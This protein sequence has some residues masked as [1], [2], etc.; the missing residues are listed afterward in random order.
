MKEVSDLQITR[1]GLLKGIFGFVGAFGLG[2][3]LY[4]AYRFMAPGA[5]AY[6]PVEVSLNDIPP[7]GTYPFQYG[8]APGLLFRAEDGSLRAFSLV[9][10][11]LACTVTWN[12]E[13]RTFYCP[14]HD[15]L[16]DAEGNVISGPPPIPLERLKVGTKGDKIT[17]GVAG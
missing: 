8:T 10:T 7:G 14:C 6:A 16:F 15:G 11:N 4:G 13:K 12:P 2:S 3:I 5:G 9:C 1:R 17:I